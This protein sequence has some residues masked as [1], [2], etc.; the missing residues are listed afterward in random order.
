[1]GE[2]HGPGRQ[3]VRVRRPVRGDGDRG[4]ACGRW[5]PHSQGPLP[6]MRL[7]CPADLAAFKVLWP[8]LYPHCVLK[9]QGLESMMALN[10]TSG[11]PTHYAVKNG[12]ARFDGSG[13]RRGRL[14]RDNTWPGGQRPN[15]LSTAAYDAYLFGALAEASLYAL[16]QGAAQMYAARSSQALESVV[17][18]RSTRQI[19]CATSGASEVINANHHIRRYSGQ[20]VKRRNA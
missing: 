20:R 4:C 7:R 13:R 5:K 9:P 18:S 17:V 15:W 12:A 8:S 16:D 14:L 10:R 1:M 11:V 19:Q 2:A 6:A 3:T